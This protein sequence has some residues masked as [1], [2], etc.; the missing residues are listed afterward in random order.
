MTFKDE[1]LI[2]Y[3]G[4]ILVAHCVDNG[5]FLRN[6]KYKALEMWMTSPKKYDQPV[7]VWAGSLQMQDWRE[8]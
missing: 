8:A 6:E 5:R 2:W 4:L 3:L 1:A 7:R